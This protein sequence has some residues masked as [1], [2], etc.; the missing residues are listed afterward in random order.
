[1]S[2]CQCDRGAASDSSSRS[3][4]AERYPRGHVRGA[5]LPA[6]I[7][8]EQN[9][10]WGQPS[11]IT[12]HPGA[13]FDQATGPPGA[14]LTREGMIAISEYLPDSKIACLVRS[15]ALS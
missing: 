5:R 1:M 10:L 4:S 7:T 15:L 12:T 13:P 8:I 2:I 14:G 6:H 9:H 11:K 3:G